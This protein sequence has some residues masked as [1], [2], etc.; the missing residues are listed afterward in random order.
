MIEFLVNSKH[1]TEPKNN[2]GNMKYFVIFALT[3]LFMSCSSGTEIKITE[4]SYEDGYPAVLINLNTCKVLAADQEG[5]KKDFQADLWIEPRDPEIAGR[6]DALMTIIE[7]DMSN[8]EIL[9]LNPNKKGIDRDSIEEGLIFVVKSNVGRYYK[10]TITH[11]SQ[12]NKEMSL[13]CVEIK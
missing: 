12:S 10:L 3:A 11:Y 13:K 7:K 6:S 2:Y 8:D 1:K 5:T 9:D 4:D